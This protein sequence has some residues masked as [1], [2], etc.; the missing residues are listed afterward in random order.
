MGDAFVANGSQQFSTGLDVFEQN[1]VGDDFLASLPAGTYQFVYAWT[2]YNSDAL[3]GCVG[4]QCSTPTVAGP[5]PDDKLQ[6][7]PV[8]QGGCSAVSDEHLAWGTG[9]SGGWSPS[10]A[11]WNSGQVCT[12]TLH[13]DVSLGRWVVR[14]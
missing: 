2:D 5:S 3:V 12:R 10:W 11:D 14:P 8:P 13:F 1:P 4:A 7:V 9:L 6:Q